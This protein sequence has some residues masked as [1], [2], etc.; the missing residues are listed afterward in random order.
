MDIDT[1][2]GSD[3]RSV[4][5]LVRALIMYHSDLKSFIPAITADQNLGRDDSFVLLLREVQDMLEQKCWFRMEDLR[6]RLQSLMSGLREIGPRLEV[7]SWM[8]Q[9]VHDDLV[10]AEE[11]QGVVG[12]TVGFHA[13]DEDKENEVVRAA[14]REVYVGQK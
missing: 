14:Q 13:C 5:R 8:G 4:L 11:M 2:I 10:T 6:R 9:M 7:E 3:L 1:D 12:A